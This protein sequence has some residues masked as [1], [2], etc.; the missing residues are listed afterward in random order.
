[1][2]IRLQRN[3][4]GVITFL[5]TAMLIAGVGA[6]SVFSQQEQPLDVQ[7]TL[8]QILDTL[9]KQQVQIDR[10]QQT[11]EQQSETIQRQQAIIDR[12]QQDLSQQ[13]EQIEKTSQSTGLDS[14][15]QYKVAME[16]QHVA[17]FDV[18]R[19][20]QPAYF[21]RCVEEFRKIVEEW[22]NSMHAP[23]A[24][25]RIGRIYHRYLK[26]YDKA[27]QEYETLIRDY[28]QSEYVEEAREAL[29]DLRSR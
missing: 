25:Y 21:E 18:R 11:I 20:E 23:E 5:A 15:V 4:R 7:K 17:I 14:V 29:A 1:M 27:V 10:L 3:S 24:Q 8:R 16:L 2:M 9:Q 28:P 22:P 26:E 6:P 19:R 13:Q 12:Q